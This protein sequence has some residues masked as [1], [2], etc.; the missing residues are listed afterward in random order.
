M[1][2]AAVCSTRSSMPACKRGRRN[3]SVTGLLG[4]GDTA[5]KPATRKAE[6]G[7]AA[8]H[9]HSHSHIYCA[10]GAQISSSGGGTR[11]RQLAEHRGCKGARTE[12][13][14][15][16]L[17]RSGSTCHA[18]KG[19]QRANVPEAAGSSRRPLALLETSSVLTWRT[20]STS[21]RSSH[22]YGAGRAQADAEPRRQGVRAPSCHRRRWHHQPA[23]TGGPCR[24]PAV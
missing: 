11:G 7:W 4:A 21:Q 20:R 16:W 13:H 5:C 2:R 17:G 24:N 18:Y 6:R 19:Y 15:L 9:R 22:S 23:A 12:L 10:A 1:P 8:G 3:R 14:R